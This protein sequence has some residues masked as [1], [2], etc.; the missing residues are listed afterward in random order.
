MV[1]ASLT[2]YD[3]RMSRP[4]SIRLTRDAEADLISIG[5][6]LRGDRAIPTTRGDALGYGLKL[7][8]RYMQHLLKQGQALPTIEQLDEDTEA[9]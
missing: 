9:V 6:L 3:V 8:R 4:P 1:G 2:C 7:S 5:A